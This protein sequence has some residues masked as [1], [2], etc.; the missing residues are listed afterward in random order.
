MSQ[1]ELIVFVDPS[2]GYRGVHNS[3]FLD[4]L[5]TSKEH[6]AHYPRTLLGAAVNKRISTKW[7]GKLESAGVHVLPAFELDGYQL[8]RQGR[9]EH[10]ITPYVTELGAEFANLFKALRQRWPGGKIHL[11]YHTMSWEHVMALAS[12]LRG[13]PAC[14]NLV[15]HVF[16]MYW[17]GI[18]ADGKTTDAELKIRY[19]I[20]LSNFHSSQRVK[21]YTSTAEYADA[22]RSIIGNNS[23][24]DLHPFFLDDWQCPAKAAVPFDS[25]K[26]RK[27][28]AY[29][30][31]VRATKGF[32]DLP[33]LIETL[34]RSFSTAEEIIIHLTTGSTEIPKQFQ[35]TYQTI[36]KQAKK[37]SRIKTVHRFMSS[38]EM[39]KL[40]ESVDLMSLNY[41]SEFYKNKTSGFL[42]LAA[43]SG[44]ACIVPA[45]TWMARE[46]KRLGIAS[47]TFK[48][49]RLVENVEKLPL[50]SPQE[51]SLYRQNVL[52]AFGPWLE[53]LTC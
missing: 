42:W 9:S 12:A 46:A 38:D 17:P 6:D 30:G 11:V 51:A 23:S 18:D 29:S 52:Q 34:A 14:Q 5:A 37:D 13:N 16:L 45:N 20:A 32:G 49:T 19:K 36:I 22:Y 53:K 4:L 3:G 44:I 41:H 27:I 24:V 1:N 26:I 28:L 2:A 43:R 21:F 7:N 35:A 8:E 33:S 39:K 15:H 25:K 31:D 10:N 47:F 50:W 48:N 40:I